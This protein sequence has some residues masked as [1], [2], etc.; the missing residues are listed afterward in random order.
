MSETP[1]ERFTA[2]AGRAATSSD[3]ISLRHIREASNRL[4]QS[5]REAMEDTGSA[6]D[7]GGYV[8]AEV[9]TGGALQ[10]VSVSAY[11]MRDLDAEALG[12]ACR[13]AILAAR[14]EAGSRLSA[15]L[16]DELGASFDAPSPDSVRALLERARNR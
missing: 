3:E 14:A 16:R 15:R 8:T 12:R 5:L 1:M 4:V 10:S 13:D 7:P 11:A 9:S 6:S 2:V